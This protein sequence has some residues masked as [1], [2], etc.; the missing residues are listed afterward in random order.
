V[1]SEAEARVAASLALLTGR[2]VG[3]GSSEGGG[4]V[5]GSS[6][7]STGA[8]PNAAAGEAGND[9]GGE[10]VVWLPPQGQTGD[11]RTAL[12]EKFGY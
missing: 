10:D 2:A 5:K 7:G 9:G 6:S 3:N 4:Q 12:N 8:N 1:Q 11:G